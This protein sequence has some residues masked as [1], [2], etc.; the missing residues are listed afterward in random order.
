[1]NTFQLINP[2]LDNRLLLMIVLLKTLLVVSTRISGEYLGDAKNNSEV[3]NSLKK[4]F[5]WAQ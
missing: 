4:K 2:E 3:L 5:I 1:M